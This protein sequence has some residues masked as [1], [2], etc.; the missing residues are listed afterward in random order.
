METEERNSHL[1][2]HVILDEVLDGSTEVRVDPVV[3]VQDGGV[4]VGVVRYNLYRSTS[5]MDTWETW[6]EVRKEGRDRYEE[7]SPGAC[8]SPT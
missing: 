2:L 1:G 8:S 4:Q 7:D 6:L 3:L 5:S